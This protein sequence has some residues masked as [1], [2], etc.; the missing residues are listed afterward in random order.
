MILNVRLLKSNTFTKWISGITRKYMIRNEKICLKI[1]V[2]SLCE[3]IMESYLRWFSHVQR[4][5]I[6]AQVRKNELIQIER[7][8]KDKG[9]PKIT[10]IK[11]VKI[12]MLIKNIIENI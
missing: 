5:E 8:K 4:R 1:N 3:K 9:R 2:V 6:T 7:T 11:I 12:D 10:L